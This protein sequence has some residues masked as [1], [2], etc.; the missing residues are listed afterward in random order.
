MNYSNKRIQFKDLI[1]YSDIYGI[2]LTD[3]DVTHL[4]DISKKY[5]GIGQN[6]YYV[7]KRI[8]DTFDLALL[9][10]DRAPDHVNLTYADETARKIGGNVFVL[11]NNRIYINFPI[12]KDLLGCLALMLYYQH[13]QIPIVINSL[14]ELKRFIFIDN[15]KSFISNVQLKTIETMYALQ[16]KQQQFAEVDM[17]DSV[18]AKLAKT[19]PRYAKKILDVLQLDNDTRIA[20]FAGFSN[21][22]PYSSVTIDAYVV[23]PD[24]PAYNFTDR[25]RYF[26]HPD[27]EKK[28]GK[29][30]FSDFDP[31]LPS[32]ERPL[33]HFVRGKGFTTVDNQTLDIIVRREIRRE[34]EEQNEKDAQKKLVDKFNDRIKQLDAG[35]SFSYNDM[36][37]NPKSIEYENQVLE[38]SNID[39]KTIL[40]YFYN[41]YSEDK[42]NFD[43]IFETFVNQVVAKAL[44][45]HKAKGRIG[46]VEYDIKVVVKTD[47]DGNQISRTIRVNKYRIN[48][49]EI[50]SVLQ[51]ALCYTSTKDFDQFLESVAKCSLRYHRVLASG[52]NLS[53][54]DEILN[55]QINFKI[56]LEREKN[57]NYITIGEKK[58]KVGDT[59]RVL[60][61]LNAR[62]MSRVIDV[63]LDKDTVGV[64]GDDIRHI[65]EEGK[66]AFEEQKEREQKL[67]DQTIQ[68]FG[69]TEERNVSLTNGRTIMT[70]YV[71]N[72][73]KRRYVIDASSLNVFEYP[74]GRYLCMVDKGQNESVNTF[75]LVG[76]MYALANDSKLASEITTL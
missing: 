28:Y 25:D 20:F 34:Q 50:S 23:T 76:R 17:R 60:T 63:L 13:F 44:G 14:D 65:I 62:A 38:D 73:K 19:M 47:P 68:L 56:N 22:N 51:R 41:Q 29:L 54:I 10:N 66:K 75:R 49:D 24:E 3:K 74:T 61:L 53:V 48:K 59:N 42:L 1:T 37:F 21:N 55:K 4:E 27:N 9:L 40:G 18:L 5:S 71:V 32:D 6:V 15:L 26:S 12:D 33:D 36:T 45:A 52:I 35:K 46:N 7:Y 16:G 39:T 43:R 58:F 30:Y 70:G 11:P 57:K 8:S 31:L 2:G 67:L 72:G 69:I 64:T